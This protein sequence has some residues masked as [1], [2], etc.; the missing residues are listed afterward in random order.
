MIPSILSIMYE[1]KRLEDDTF[2]GL[3]L[4]CTMVVFVI[5]C[6][7]EKSQQHNNN[8]NQRKKQAGPLEERSKPSYIGRIEVIRESQQ[9]AN[10]Q[11]INK[12]S[13][14]VEAAKNERPDKSAHETQRVQLFPADDEPAPGYS[15]CLTP[16]AW[17]LPMP[18]SPQQETERHEKKNRKTKKNAKHKT[19][20]KKTKKDRHKTAQ[21]SPK[22]KKKESEKK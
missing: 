7:A 16:K 21:A 15:S 8:G 9:T 5:R 20:A 1:R 3:V 11:T 14:Q 12:Q 17:D 19:R 22:H 18:P 10:E 4:L 2:A 6:C 13:V